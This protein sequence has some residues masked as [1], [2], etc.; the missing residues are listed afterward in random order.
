MIDFQNPN[1]NQD[2][3][4][5]ANL[6]VDGDD[7]DVPDVG[8]VPDVDDVTGVEDVPDI[9]DDVGEDEE[10]GDI[11]AQTS[12]E[13]ESTPLRRKAKG[14]GKSSILAA[15]ITAATAASAKATPVKAAPAKA[16]PKRKTKAAPSIKATP[17]PTPSAKASTAKATPTDPRATPTNSA[18]NFEPTAS[19]SSGVTHGPEE[20][21][22]KLAL[23][24]DQLQANIETMVQ[25]ALDGTLTSSALSNQL[26]AFNLA[27]IG[28]DESSQGKKKPGSITVSNF[29]LLVPPRSPQVLDPFDLLQVILRFPLTPSGLP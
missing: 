1:D 21:P 29:S 7:V 10:Y 24:R 19:T 3:A 14:P 13:D 25:E 12:S 2:P 8:D 16:T 28:S 15:E 20:A 27:C 4:N 22:N 6:D 9:R 11:P 5:T 17:A 18:A 26:V 23:I